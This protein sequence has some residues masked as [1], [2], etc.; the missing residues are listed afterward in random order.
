MAPLRAGHAAGAADDARRASASASC[1]SRSAG[2]RSRAEPGRP[3]SPSAYDWGPSGD[4]LD[5]AARAGHRRDRDALRLA[6]LGERRRHRRAPAD[7]RVRRLR[8]RGRA[9]VSRGCTCGP[10][11]TSRTA[12]RSPCPSR[13]A[14]TSSAAQSGVRVAP[15]GLAANSSPA[16]SPRRGRPRRGC[17]RSRSCRAC[18]RRTRGSTRTRRTLS[19]RARRDAVP[20]VRARAARYLTMAKLPAIRADVT[21]Y[22]GAQAAVADGVRLP[23]ESARPAARRLVCAA[24]ARTSARRRSASGSRAASPC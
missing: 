18:T 24:G 19:G 10:P 15:P 11:G 9:R 4:L 5:G 7:D 1:G 2:T 8:V 21:R 16:A 14:S 6:A 13:R 23:D 22:F 17:R 12:G 3:R 20:H